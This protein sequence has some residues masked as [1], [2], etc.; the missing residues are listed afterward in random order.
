MSFSYS[1]INAMGEITFSEIKE[2]IE[3]I[4]ISIRKELYKCQR[5]ADEIILTEPD[6]L[7]LLGISK[8]TLAYIKERREISFSKP[9]SH[10]SCYFFLSDILD[11]L[12]ESRLESIANMRKI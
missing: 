2:S 5:P 6:V 3:G 7:K 11:W 1:K 10:S 12:K 4:L 8:R 9:H